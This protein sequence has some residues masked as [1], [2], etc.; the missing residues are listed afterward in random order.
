MTYELR[1]KLVKFCDRAKYVCI[2][3]KL[4]GRPRVSGFIFD[5]G[6]ELILVHQF[7]DFYP[8]GLAVLRI[9]DIK[10]VRH[11]DRER[12]I[13]TIIAKE[14]LQT[15]SN[16]IN[17]PLANMHGLLQ[18]LHERDDFCIIECESTISEK[19][20]TFSIGQIKSI[21]EHTIHF[22]WFDSKGVWSE[23]IETIEVDAITQCQ[24]N[25]PYTNIITRYTRDASGKEIS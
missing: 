2:T 16:H 5:V 13:G 25:T 8:E 15:L 19:L 7:H 11:S 4:A 17:L 9:E 24:I 23:E 12:F 10:S 14:N 1:A 20:N 21:G 3:R 6:A 22:K 18:C